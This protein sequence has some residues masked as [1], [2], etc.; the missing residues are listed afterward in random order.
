DED[1]LTKARQASYGLKEL[2][3]VPADYVDTYFDRVNGGASALTFRNDLRRSVI[4]GRHDLVQDAPISRLDLLV[5][6]NTLMY[7]NAET[8]QRILERFNFAL[9]S[10]AFLFLGKAET[11]LTQSSLFEPVDLRL[12]I[13]Q[14]SGGFT[15]YRSLSMPRRE[16]GGDPPD[17]ISLNDL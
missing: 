14:K 8:Q 2:D 15:R 12:R 9:G 1:A 10:N 4:F 17:E 13:F 16:A 3:G 7:F 6:R 5:C 11:L